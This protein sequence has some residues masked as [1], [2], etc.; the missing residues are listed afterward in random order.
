MIL[1]IL[2]V[3]LAKI[4]S[5]LY[6]NSSAYKAVISDVSE[7]A[8]IILDAGHGGEDCGAIGSNGALEKDLNFEITMLLGEILTNR[9]FAVIYT[10]TE[11]ALLYT[12]E[13]N[14]Y[15]IRKINDLKNRCKIGAEYPSA[16]YISIHMNSYKSPECTGLQVYYSENN[17]SSNKLASCIQNSVKEKLQSENK[18]QIKNGKG[19]Y[20]LENLNNTAVLIECGFL[21][22]L[23]ECEKLSQKEYQ[24]ELS[25]AILCGIIEYTR[26]WQ[27]I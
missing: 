20:I 24:K 17:Q 25:F 2:S 16:I 14:I 10:R 22:N 26:I 5:D 18:R 3:L 9:G 19:M 13:Q 27:N 6:I 4:T 1:I 15:G 8:T 21:T 11:D 7:K 12:E 23:K